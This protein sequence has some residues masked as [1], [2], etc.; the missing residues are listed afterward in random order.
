MATQ[1]TRVYET[2]R[3]KILTG[4]LPPS[5]SLPEQ[6]L[7]T[8]YNVSRNTLK[9]ALLMLEK[10]SLV[11]I[12]SNKGAKVRSYSMDEVLDYLELR[13]VLEGFI[14]RKAVPVISD[15]SISEMESILE[16]MKT[17]FN[18][19]ELIQYSQFNLR[20]HQIIYDACPNNTAVEMTKQLKTQMSKY[21]TKTILVPGRDTQSLNEHTA[22]LEAIKSRD[23]QLAEALIVRH[24]LNVRKTFQDNY[25]ILF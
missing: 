23:A 24:V 19:K 18:S 4:E 14:I 20:F 22:I 17:Y 16:V 9:K 25:S 8:K 6:E 7:S 13:S 3:N 1:T 12:E 15:E 21:N 2:L 10:E 11:S 5:A